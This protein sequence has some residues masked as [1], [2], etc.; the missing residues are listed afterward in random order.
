LHCDSVVELLD[1]FVKTCLHDNRL[2]YVTLDSFAHLLQHTEVPE[3]YTAINATVDHL[4]ALKTIEMRW[5][6]G[7]PSAVLT[8]WETDVHAAFSSLMQC[9]ILLITKFQ[10]M[11]TEFL[12]LEPL[13]IDVSS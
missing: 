9:G 12:V 8:Q 1:V 11:C 2:E 7:E 3:L 4:P 5:I 13:L 10:C 6:V